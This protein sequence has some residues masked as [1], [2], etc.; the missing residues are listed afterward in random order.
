M[1]TLKLHRKFTH[2]REGVTE[3]DEAVFKRG[4]E[5]IYDAGRLGCILIQFPWSFKYL[6]SN[7]QYL[8]E[9]VGR[10]SEYP[11]VIEVRNAYWDNDELYSFL[12]G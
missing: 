5:P 9:L 10:F 6:P 2:E 3:Q 1:F 12:Q 7:R 4:I 8:A 11:L